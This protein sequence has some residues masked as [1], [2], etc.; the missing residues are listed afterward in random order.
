MNLSLS[1]LFLKDIKNQSPFL[2]KNRISMN[3][4]SISRVFASFMI[5]NQEIQG[6]KCSFNLFLRPILLFDSIRQYGVYTKILDERVF[7]QECLFS[8][9]LS[10]SSYGGALY[11]IGCNLSII[12]C[13]FQ[14]C[15]SNSQGGGFALSGGNLELNNTCFYICSC[16]KTD[17]NGGNGFICTNSNTNIFRNNAYYSGSIKSNS[18]DSVF[19]IS[20]K[21]TRV[22][23]WNS[24][25]CL[26][27]SGASGGCLRYMVEGSKY[28]YGTIYNSSDY[29]SIEGW[30]SCLYVET[31][32]LL[33]NNRNDKCLIW[34]NQN[35]YMIFRHCVFY[36]NIKAMDSFCSFTIEDCFSDYSY[37]SMSTTSN[38]QTL[39]I[40]TNDHCKIL[41]F[42]ENHC[43][44]YSFVI[45]LGPLLHFSSFLLFFE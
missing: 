7:F 3:L 32:N 20:Q 22:S 34:G 10:Q 45:T 14:N 16:S 12:S 26:G 43:T 6:N 9:I 40:T 39:D 29:N 24:T 31:T 18:G 8:D 35:T 41:N 27:Q 28:D 42:V 38:I 23:C 44:M 1:L 33:Y 19:D 17:E 13:R 37:L 4:C 5:T 2:S 21:L 15:R 30:Y 36:G 25:Q 11:C